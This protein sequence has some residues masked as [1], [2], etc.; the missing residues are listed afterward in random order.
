MSGAQQNGAMGAD[1]PSLNGT[2]A[3]GLHDREMNVALLGL[4]DSYITPHVLNST[5]KVKF[6]LV[7]EVSVRK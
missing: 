2:A 4:L 1:D 5:F 7:N 3:L 6:N